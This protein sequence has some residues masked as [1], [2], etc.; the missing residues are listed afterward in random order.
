MPYE[1]PPRRTD[2]FQSTAFEQANLARRMQMWHQQR[3]LDAEIEAS[4]KEMREVT[5]A[6][7]GR[8]IG[9]SIRGNGK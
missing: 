3:H 5:A 2:N 1:K 7:F 6:K 8:V 9:R 4:Q